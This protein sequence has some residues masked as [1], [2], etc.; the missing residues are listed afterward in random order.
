MSEHPEKQCLKTVSFL[1][2][3]VFG[4]RDFDRTD[5]ILDEIL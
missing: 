5:E 4:S 2:P 3:V 1:L